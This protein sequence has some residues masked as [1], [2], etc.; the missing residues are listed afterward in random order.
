MRV[1][2]CVIVSGIVVTC[3]AGAF[4]EVGKVDVIVSSRNIANLVIESTI[5][6]SAKVLFL[7]SKDK[8]CESKILKK[9][10][11]TFTVDISKCNE[12]ELKTGT[13]V[14]YLAEDSST[15][16]PIKIVEPQTEKTEMVHKFGIGFRFNNKLRYTDGEF[17]SGTL[18][19]TGTLEYTTSD[20]P[21]VLEWNFSST[22]R[23][24]WGWGG[25]ITY[26]VFRWD[27]VTASGRTGSATLDTSGSTRVIS[28]FINAIYRWDN[29]YTRRWVL[30][31]L[32]F[33]IVTRLFL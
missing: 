17:T 25:G 4:S 19:E 32:R 28:P 24:A 15:D 10:Q 21:I 5:D 30:I 2:A 31:P 13:S 27:K 1:G 33:L 20:V 22:L 6:E 29:S 9:E 3:A 11:S 14:F 16:G 26:T 18:R 23:N 8:N 12:V 7:G